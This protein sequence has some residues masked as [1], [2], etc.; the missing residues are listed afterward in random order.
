MSQV[1]V[2]TPDSEDHWLALRSQ[3]L[4]STEIAGLFGC[5]PYT[6]LFELWHRKRDRTVVDFQPTERMIWGTRLQDSI[7]RGMSE[8]NGWQIRRM[9]EY[10]RIP[11][12]RVGSS[13]DFSIVSL[14]ESGDG[15]IGLLEIKNVDSLAFR[16]GWIEHDNGT[17][18][19]PP[20]IELQVQHQLMVSG[21]KVAFIGALVG[22]N[23]L[24]QIKREPDPKIIGAIQDRVDS[25]WKSIERGQE[26][27]PDFSRD[28]EFIARLCGFAQPGKVLDARGDCEIKELVAR[29][30]EAG[31]QLKELEKIRNAVKSRILLEIGLAEKVI[32][33]TFTI[34]AGMIGPTT[35]SYERQGYR[36]FRINFKRAKGGE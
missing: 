35:V 13:F 32:G 16:G 10:L 4:T 22:G 24:V 3:D 7:A 12:L 26:P 9:S 6:T 17:I 1:Q 2:I 5:S 14:G 8:D 18:E 19:A 31:D 20:E 30:K 15:E 11:D 23:R 25:F 29:Y 36:N 34:S 27:N 33:D 28:V 21:R